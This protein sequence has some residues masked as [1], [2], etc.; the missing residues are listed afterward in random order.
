MTEAGFCIITPI[1]VVFLYL[2]GGL[3]TIFFTDSSDDGVECN[4]IIMLIWPLF[5]ACL[6]IAFFI[7]GLSELF[8]KIFK[9]KA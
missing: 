3:F 5:W 8:K 6:V 1:I 2:L 4:I 7:F 9:R